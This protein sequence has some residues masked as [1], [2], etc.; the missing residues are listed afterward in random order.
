V[1][2]SGGMGAEDMSVWTG[3]GEGVWNGKQ[4]VDQEGDKI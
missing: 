4:R 2:K 3:D 1:E